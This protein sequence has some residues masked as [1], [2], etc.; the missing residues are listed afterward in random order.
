MYIISIF[1]QYFLFPCLAFLYFRASPPL[2]LSL[3]LSLFLFF[4]L[5]LSVSLSLSLSLSLPLSPLPLSH[6]PFS[7]YQPL[8]PLSLPFSP[9]LSLPS[10]TLPLLSSLFLYPSLLTQ[11][12]P[13]LSNSVCMSVYMSLPMFYS[14]A[15]PPYTIIWVIFPFMGKKPGDSY[16]PIYI[17][18][19]EFI[20]S[21]DS[22]VSMHPLTHIHTSYT[23][24]HTHISYNQNDMIGWESVTCHMISD[25]Y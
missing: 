17:T 13:P 9:Y 16:C 20:S 2:S 12:S 22:S 18:A 23:P 1:S 10:L 24:K 25:C 7:L 15:S 6:L 11:S 5:P 3:F 21:L 4:S 14:L 8:L 19:N